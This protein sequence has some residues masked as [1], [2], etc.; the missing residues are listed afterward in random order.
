MA[1]EKRI[2]TVNHGTKLEWQNQARTQKTGELGLATD[3]REL[4]IG[5]GLKSFF[6][7]PTLLEVD[8][9]ETIK[10]AL[11][12]N[13]TLTGSNVVADM[14]ALEDG[15]ATKQDEIAAN[16]LAALEGNT[17]LSGTNPVADEAALAAGLG[18]KQ[19]ELA[20]NILAALEGN[21]ALSGSNVVADRM[22]T[23]SKGTGTIYV[24]KT[25]SDSSGSGTQENPFASLE[26]ALAALPNVVGNSSANVGISIGPGL[27]EETRL[28]TYGKVGILRIT[29]TNAEDKPIIQPK[30]GI[31]AGQ[32]FWTLGTAALSLSNI[33]FQDPEGA[34]QVHGLSLE[35]CTFNIQNCEFRGFGQI[36]TGYTSGFIITRSMGQV[37]NST[38]SYC[39]IGIMCNGAGH[40]FEMSNT[41]TNI[42]AQGIR[43]QGGTT[44]LSLD[45]SETSVA[46]SNYILAPSIL[47]TGVGLLNSI[48]TNTLIA[49]NGATTLPAGGTWA[50]VRTVGTTTTTGVSAGGTAI[51]A[52]NA[53]GFALQIAA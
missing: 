23:A 10:A 37:L 4:K 29:A 20:A 21:A 43:A 30:A 34:R 51:G 26:K 38:F 40:L 13:A 42:L 49:I 47:V 17:S 22:N 53:T 32:A 28:E 1:D 27:Y 48:N 39:R 25:G 33:I 6:D 14:A 46:T 11:E 3:S 15:L 44:V 45:R 18:T 12:G 7:L 41:F 5:D 9:A 31:A 35:D 36:R 52:T 16:I 50:W 8:N 2:I 24:A 19:D